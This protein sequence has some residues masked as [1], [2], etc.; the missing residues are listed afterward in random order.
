MSDR[1]E[2]EVS[3]GEAVYNADGE[4]IGSVRGV[5]EDGFFVT[6]REGVEAMS[7]EHERAGQT[8]G[9]AE[10]LW[11]CADCGAVGDIADMPDEC[12]DCG[13]QREALFYWIED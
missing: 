10:L 9:E 3:I 6:T 8:F 12:P 2:I 4:Q 11:R 13:A 7:V 5:D 1:R